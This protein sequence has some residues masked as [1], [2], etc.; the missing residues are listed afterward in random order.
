MLD[1]VVM[2]A[3]LGTRMKSSR[4][5]VLHEL[6]GRPLVAHV[7]RA[8]AELDPDRLVVVVGHQADLV[9]EAARAG[10][11]DDTTE[12]RFALQAEQLGTGHAV[13]QTVEHLS[14]G[15]V[16]VLSGDV[17]LVRAG[18]LRALLD[19]HR[20]D[21]NAATLLTT[22]LEDATGYGRIVRGEG[23]RFVRIVEHR[24]ADDEERAIGEI[25]AGIYAFEAES[26]VPA[27]ARLSTGN[28]QGEYYLTDVLGM[29]V[30]EGRPV[31]VVRHD[32]PA[33]VLGINTRVELAESAAVLRRRILD[34]LMLSGVTIVDPASTYV[35]DTVE[36]GPDTIVHPGA[37]LSGATRVGA[38]CEIGPYSHLT[39]VDIGEGVLVRAMCVLERARVARGAQ[40]GPF[41]RLRPGA[42]LG[43][44]VHVGNFVEVKN[45]TLG[46]GSKANHLTYLG[47]A[48]IGERCNIGAGTITCNY[49]G[50][51]KHRTTIED[52]VYIGSDTM[53]VAPVRVGRGSKTGAGAVVT[54]DIP[55]RSLAVG[56][57]AR[58]ARTIDDQ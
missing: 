37:I 4:A 51:R 33:E 17:P 13:Q 38:N 2:A 36:I 42:D 30:D 3:G 29:L 56:V 40:I 34:R 57:P 12:L 19:A 26:L 21:G 5:K 9:E 1:I 25:N 15:T 23:D 14:G 58:V 22:A 6:V 18:T 48:E 8:A 24:D 45:S 11:G 54:K 53:L 55:E 44:E 10:L 47:D 46:A 52:D 41:A 35:D 50:K 27:L 16:L 7:C 39:D 20:D 31:G 49:D 28:S 43:E 32:E